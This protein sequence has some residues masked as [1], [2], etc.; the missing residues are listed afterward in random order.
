M[1]NIA[2]FYSKEE[3]KKM[4]TKVKHWPLKLYLSI[5][6][7]CR[8]CVDGSITTEEVFEGTLQ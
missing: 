7:G 1:T 4:L 2:D 3:L 6:R 5:P 8:V